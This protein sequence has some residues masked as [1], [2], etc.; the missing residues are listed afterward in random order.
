[1]SRITDVPVEFVN[2]LQGVVIMLVAAEMFLAKWKHKLIVKNAQKQE[3][4]KEA[5]K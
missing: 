2:I 4:A 5:A 3:I 1:M